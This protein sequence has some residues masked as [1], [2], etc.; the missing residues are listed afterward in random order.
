M[1]RPWLSR[2]LGLE[3]TPFASLGDA[4]AQLDV[5]LPGV[6]GGWSPRLLPRPDDPSLAAPGL[7]SAAASPSQT[8]RNTPYVAGSIRRATTAPAQYSGGA[9][10]RPAAA[11]PPTLRSSVDVVQPVPGSTRP[12][13]A[14]A[15]ALTM[16]RLRRRLAAVTL[17][18]GAQAVAIVLLLWMPEW[19]PIPAAPTGGS[20]TVAAGRAEALGN[21]P[22]QA[23]VESAAQAIDNRM[24]PAASPSS[25]GWLAVTSEVPIRIFADGKLLGAT[26]SGSFQLQAGEHDLIVTNEAVGYRLVQKVRI[27][28]GRTMHIAP[29][30]AREVTPGGR[31][32]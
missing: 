22:G 26:R 13:V 16:A 12:H 21:A 6:V 14:S 30:L 17:L 15:D 9:P 2:A 7:R 27:R 4:Q 24:A 11:R 18:A 29:A 19:P 31:D 8:P 32:R 28:A 25:A 5:L 1:L 23:G 3:G 20:T 10:P